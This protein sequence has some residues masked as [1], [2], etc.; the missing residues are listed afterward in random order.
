M[1][2]FT[3]TFF[4]LSKTVI[5]KKTFSPIKAMNEGRFLILKYN[6]K[7]SHK[8]SYKNTGWRKSSV[9]IMFICVF[10][11]NLIKFYS[12]TI[13]TTRTIYLFSKW[14]PPASIHFFKRF[15]KSSTALSMM[16]W[17]IAFH[18]FTKLFFNASI[19]W[20]GFEHASASKM[21]QIE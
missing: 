7:I 9:H 12:K 2:K 14:P 1:M 5:L 17:G 3:S 13:I 18:A 21:L 4:I 11:Y 8:D 20:W 19:D 10:V 15:G 16:S 6:Y